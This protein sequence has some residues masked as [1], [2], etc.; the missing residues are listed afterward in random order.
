MS[1]PETPVVL[2]ID[3][4]VATVR[5]MRLVLEAEGFAVETAASRAAAL[6]HLHTLKPDVVI[7]DYLMGGLTPE[8]F[9]ESA[10]AS[11]LMAPILL[12]TGMQNR[13]VQLAVDD[14]LVKPFDIDELVERVRA[15]PTRSSP[16]ASSS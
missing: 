8:A 7:M 16:N 12:C 4:D 10:R 15:L 6:E 9:I 13:N 2:V 3:D 14:I 5:M 1:A 11:G